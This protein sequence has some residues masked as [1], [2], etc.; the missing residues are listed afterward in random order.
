MF[1]T[2]KLTIFAVITAAAIV[3]VAGFLFLYDDT[4]RYNITYELN[5]GTLESDIPTSYVPGQY[6]KVADP[7]KENCIFNGWY[8]DAD[9]TTPFNGMTIDLTGDITLYA[10]WADNLSGHTVTLTKSGYCE[11]GF[12]SYKIDGDLTFT[13]LYYNSDKESYFIENSDNT[14]YTY[15][16]MG[17]RSYSESTSSTYWND[18]IDGDW[19]DLGMETI[20]V[21]IEGE[22]VQKE[23]NKLQL[24]YASG[25]TETQWIGD[26]WIPYQIVF[27]YSQ[28]SW[29]QTNE[30]KIV[31]SYQSDGYVDI[32]SDCE[33]DVVEG[34]GI[35]V[36]G[37]DGPYKLGES[38][39]LT[40]TAADGVKFSGWY[41]ENFV[42]L[43]TDQT[44]KFVIGGSIKLYAMNSNTVD[45]TFASD[46][47]VNLNIEGDLIDAQYIITN[48]DSLVSDVSYTDTYTFADGGMYRVVGVGKNSSVFYNVKVTGDVTRTYEWTFDKKTYSIELDIDYDDLLYARGIYKASERQQ[49][50]SHVRDKTFVTYSYTDKVMAPYMEELVD[51]LVKELNKNYSTV[52]EST[53]L[54]Y[55]LAFTQYI[56]YQSDE[57]YMGTSEYWK[58]PLETL[59]DQGGDCEDTSILFIALAHECRTVYNMSY[60][61]ALQLL[62]GHMAG[63]VKLTTSVTKNTNP[64]GYT[65]GETT[66]TGYSLGEI[67]DTMKD[68]FISKRYYSQGYSV[69]VEIA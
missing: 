42:L 39:T 35:T 13:Y 7:D 45:I 65:Y 30:I 3:G 64:E 14:T 51:K 46:T 41:D 37:N 63:A 10:R 31:Y 8:L 25:A 49:E 69:T 43:S 48:A 28:S 9:Y 57:E 67:P 27:Y 62:P 40:A 47:E 44:Y 26:G 53:L 1:E 66:V 32:P 33:V 50:S 52:S 12:N 4:E 23:C 24:R 21:I 68:Y 55:L 60:K 16:Y 19:I 22:Q 54:G 18:D 6:I 36:T 11:R 2:D 59:Y 5:G 29:V 61:V 15:I 58:F 56:E 20:T 17:D 38:V 34:N